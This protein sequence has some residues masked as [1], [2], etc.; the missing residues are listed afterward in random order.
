MRVLIST[1]TFPIRPDDGTPRFVL[2]LARHLAARCTVAVLAPG[3]AG[4]P[5]REHWDGLEIRR[6]TYFLPRSAQKLAYGFGMRQNLRS[7]LARI[8]VA[9]Y[10]AALTAATRAA[11]AEWRP[12]VINTHWLVPQGLATALARP[13]QGSLPASVLSVHAGDIYLLSRLPFGRSLARYVVSRT[14]ASLADGSHVK[15]ALDGLLGTPSEATVQPMGVDLDRFGPQRS[16]QGSPDTESLIFV[17]RLVEKK[18]AVYLL[19]ALPKVL[20]HRPRVHLFVVGEGPLK[21]DLVAEAGRLGIEAA[22]SFLGRRGHD[23]VARRLGECRVAV[24]PSVVDRIG[25]TDGMPTVVVEAMAAGARV[26]GTAVDGIPDVIED[27]RNGWLCPAKDPEALAAAI[28]EALDDKGD[29]IV[30]AAFAS[31]SD[32]SWPQVA[33]RYESVFSRTCA[34]RAPRRH[35][36]PNATT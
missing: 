31:A 30:R 8:Q 20:A 11:M 6:F 29:A 24:V 36:A 12:D 9:P 5:A 21:E 16:K 19:R 1:S 7:W 26:V 33:A 34:A 23:E 10:V 17:G 13:R 27:H 35:A 28:L 4:A 15:A 2:D 22:V 3:D 14:D 25:E 32:H 18:G